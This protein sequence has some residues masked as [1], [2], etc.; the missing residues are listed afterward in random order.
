MRPPEARKEEGDPASPFSRTSPASPRRAK[1]RRWTLFIVALVLLASAVL[2]VGVPPAAAGSVGQPEITDPTGDANFVDGAAPGTAPG[3]PASLGWADI[4]KVWFTTDHDVVPAKRDGVRGTIKVPYA[5]TAHIQTAAPITPTGPGVAYVVEFQTNNCVYRIL[6]HVPGAWRDSKKA[7]LAEGP[8]CGSTSIPSQDLQ[9]PVVQGN[10]ISISVPFDIDLSLNLYDGFGL[11]KV[12]AFTAP[13]LDWYWDYRYDTDTSGYID[14]APS[15]GPRGYY[16]IG[17]DLAPRFTPGLAFEPGSITTVAGGSHGDGLPGPRASVSNAWG[18][19]VGP[20]GLVYFSDYGHSRLRR[21]AADGTVEPYS[22]FVGGYSDGGHRLRANLRGPAGMDWGPDGSLY[23]ADSLNHRVRRIWPDG[24]IRTI[25]GDGAREFSGDGGPATKASLAWPQDVAVAPNGDVYIA[26]KENV[27]V[28]KVTATTGVIST[29]TGGGTL[30]NDGPADQVALTPTGITLDVE[31][32]LWISDLDWV[33]ELDFDTN[34]VTTR[35]TGIGLAQGLAFDAD[36]SLYVADSSGKKVWRRL[37]NGTAEVFAGGGGE[38]PGD[39]GAATDAV[40]DV[41]MDVDV[42][43]D[44]TVYVAVRSEIGTYVN[45]EV[46]H[47][48]IRVIHPDA[49]IDT[50]VGTGHDKSVHDPSLPA[51]GV[52]FNYVAGLAYDD[53]GRL[54]IADSPA[55]G[56]VIIPKAR[57]GGGR[58]WR[59]DPNGSIR[60]VAGNGDLGDDAAEDD[61]GPALETQLGSPRSID[62]GPDGLVWI[63]D[64]GNRTIRVYDPVAGTITKVAGQQVGF[65]HG[66][67]Q[68]NELPADEANLYYP[69][70]LAVAPNGDVYWTEASY[71]GCNPS[72]IRMYRGGKVYLVA[73]TR[74]TNQPNPCGYGGDGKVL[75]DQTR[76]NTPEGLEFDSAGNLLIADSYNARIRRVDATTRVIDTIA[77]DGGLEHRDGTVAAL[78]SFAYPVDVEPVPGGGYLVAEQ[79]IDGY[80]IRNRASGPYVSYVAPNGMVTRVAGNGIFDLERDDSALATALLQPNAIALSPAGTVAIADYH[81]V[82]ILTPDEGGL[83][84]PAREARCLPMQ[85]DTAG[86]ARSRETLNAHSTN[87]PAIDLRDTSVDTGGGQLSAT[88]KVEDLELAHVLANDQYP[89]SAYAWVYMFTDGTGTYNKYLAAIGPISLDDPTAA[90]GYSFEWGDITGGTAEAMNFTRRGAATGSIDYAKDTVTISAP[91]ASVGLQAG[92]R[93]LYHTGLTGGLFQ[94][95]LAKFS[96]YSDYSPYVTLWRSV[97]VGATCPGS[98]Q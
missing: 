35:M 43:A 30:A 21:V 28:R 44:G 34:T 53:Q 80:T 42:A 9:P 48:R 75:S 60:V 91:L 83:P 36:G 26:D 20:D 68:A 62:V 88:L 12:R 8:P 11:S 82:R 3:T 17:S 23:F 73:G 16:E 64:V 4:T 13:Y 87:N 49:T 29:V 79:G 45:G 51:L 59:L 25:A 24:T 58:L 10:T 81:R 37:A 32:D 5:F 95:S 69:R 22:G 94:Y 14:F 2:A 93:I 76:L 71:S 6:A 55:P 40:M 90:G 41:P 19:G 54:Y 39:G 66:G 50:Y 72:R 63:A 84:Q 1:S 67:S 18:V 47:D 89:T 46:G 96:V 57:K 56:G 38:N 98:Y 33:R 27:R 92:E 70:A 85:P 52:D 7:M 65:L 61:S 15:I 78:S 77:G 86:D 74:D 31:G 97:L